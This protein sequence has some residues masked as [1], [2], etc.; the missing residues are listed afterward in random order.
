MHDTLGQ[1]AHLASACIIDTDR[2]TCE[3]LTAERAEKSSANDVTLSP[4]LLSSPQLP[5]PEDVVTI[6]RHEPK[7]AHCVSSMLH[8]TCNLVD[9]GLDATFCVEHLEDQ[10][11][12]GKWERVGEEGHVAE[13]FIP[14]FLCLRNSVL[15]EGLN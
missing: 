13:L 10:L 14:L 1:P 6:R 5:S 8:S 12:V 3:V 11:Q 2:N 9:L 15:H 7:R 4:E